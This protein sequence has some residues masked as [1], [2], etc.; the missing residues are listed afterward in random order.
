MSWVLGVF[1]G[2]TSFEKNKYLKDG[3]ACLIKDGRIFCA[4]AEERLSRIKHDGNY[5]R[6]VRYCIDAAGISLEDIDLVVF[7]NCC[8]SPLS[9]HNSDGLGVGVRRVF[10]IASHHLSHAYLAQRMS[11]FDGCTT[12]VMDNEG[13]I[14]GDKTDEEYYWKNAMERNS[15]YV[16]SHGA[17]RSFSRDCAQPDSIGVGDT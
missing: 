17:L 7:S 13:N 8:D 10:N 4:V 16:F 12:I 1:G 6:S 3:N 14:I 5:L 15:Y 9:T 11:H 2:T